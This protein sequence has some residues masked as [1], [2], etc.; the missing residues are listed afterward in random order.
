MRFFYT[1]FYCI[2]EFS[3]IFFEEND[4]TFIALDGE[5]DKR[6]CGDMT[7]DGKI[8]IDDATMIQKSLAELITLTPEQKAAADTNA[9]GKVDINDA[10]QIQKYLAELV[11]HLG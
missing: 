3:D 8:T 9:D 7:G 2:L 10:T 11:D 4:I 6:E 1:T 5:D